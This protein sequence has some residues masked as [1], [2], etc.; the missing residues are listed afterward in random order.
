MTRLV[1][2]NKSILY[3]FCIK[4]ERMWCV[5]KGLNADLMVIQPESIRFI[6]LFSNSGTTTR[7]GF[8]EGLTPDSPTFN[9]PTHCSLL[10]FH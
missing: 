2:F 5:F 3:Q 1:R 9:M 7:L 8:F 6:L 4:E 10:R